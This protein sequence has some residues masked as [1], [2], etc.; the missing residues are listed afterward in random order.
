[1][2]LEMEQL[3]QG[4]LDGSVESSAL[5]GV[6]PGCSGNVGLDEFLIYLED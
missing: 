3:K 2:V 5:C 6:M 1:M 4:I